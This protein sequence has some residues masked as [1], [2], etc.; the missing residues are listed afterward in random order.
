MSHPSNAKPVSQPLPKDEAGDVIDSMSLEIHALLVE[1]DDDAAS[2][3]HLLVFPAYLQAFVRDLEFFEEG[4]LLCVD[5]V[6][7]R[8]WV[9]NTSHVRQVRRLVHF[10][11]NM[12]L[13]NGVGEESERAAVERLA[14]RN[15][16]PQYASPALALAMLEAHLERRPFRPTEAQ[17]HEI[18]RL[19]DLRADPEALARLKDQHNGALGYRFP[20]DTSRECR[21]ANEQSLGRIF[22]EISQRL[23]GQPVASGFLRVIDEDGYDLCLN[24]A[25]LLWVRVPDKYV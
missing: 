19:H 7:N 20:Q 23:R 16:C 12:L 2:T 17:V 4:P 15:V 9:I 6:F 10:V 14:S 8:L 18:R 24:L 1:F 22:E 21:L 13:G 3:L 25:R 11:P 5:D